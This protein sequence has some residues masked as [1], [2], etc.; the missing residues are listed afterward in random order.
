M[1]NEKRTHYKVGKLKKERERREMRM[2]IIIKM[3]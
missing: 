1:K 3:R 2:T